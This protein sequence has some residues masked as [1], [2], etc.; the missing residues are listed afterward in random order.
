[1]MIVNREFEKMGKWSWP[2]FKELSR[3]LPEEAEE[4]HEKPQSG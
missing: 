3:H 1:M 2:N 4:K